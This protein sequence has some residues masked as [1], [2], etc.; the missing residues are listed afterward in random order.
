MASFAD[1]IDEV[2]A[3]P[4]SR[5]GYLYDPQRSNSGWWQVFA[6]DLGDRLQAEICV[7][8]HSSANERPVGRGFTI[9]LYRVRLDDTD[10]QPYTVFDG[11]IDIRMSAALWMALGLRLYP[12]Y[13]HWWEPSSVTELKAALADALQKLDTYIIPWL[14]DPASR[15]PGILPA[16]E[17]TRFR[18]TLDRIGRPQL[19]RWGYVPT[20][21]R[22]RQEFL[23]VR[24]LRPDLSAF[25]DF[26]LGRS[27]DS[28]RPLFEILLQRNT[29]TELVDDPRDKHLRQTHFNSYLAEIE[30]WP[31]GNEAPKPYSR[32][33][34]SDQVELENRLVDAVTQ[35]GLHGIPWLEYSEAG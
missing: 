14:E 5:L 11:R 26:M 8:R 25:V 35:L 12:S 19:E 6:K 9:H 29:G 10:D 32:W 13:D 24:R 15:M 27:P 23:F 21:A 30:N 16:E 4:L 2:L 1:A 31:I 3:G 33:E 18:A 20:E 28:P 34:Y 17:I 7:Q 22:T